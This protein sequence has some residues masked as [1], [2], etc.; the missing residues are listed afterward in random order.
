VCWIFVGKGWAILWSCWRNRIQPPGITNF[1]PRDKRDRVTRFSPLDFPVKQLLLHL[2][3]G[4]PICRLRRHIRISFIP[5]GVDSNIQ[6]ENIVTRSF[7]AILGFKSLCC[8]CYQ[9]CVAHY[10]SVGSGFG[11][12]EKSKC[13][14]GS[15]LTCNC[16]LVQYLYWGGIFKPQT[17]CVFEL[18]VL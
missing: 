17:R 16:T 2:V 10:I 7:Q 4:Q 8:I 12:G 14:S 18:A 1:F 5:N 11:S 9:C 6:N 15:Y 3:V 13:N